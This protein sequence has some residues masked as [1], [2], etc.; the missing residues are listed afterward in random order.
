MNSKRFGSSVPSTLMAVLVALAS[1]LGHAGDD[2]TGMWGNRA[3]PDFSTMKWRPPGNNDKGKMMVNDVNLLASAVGVPHGSFTLRKMPDATPGDAFARRG[4]KGELMIYYS[5]SFEA[6]GR[7]AR[8]DYLGKYITL[9]HEIAHHLLG[10]TA[11]NAPRIT[12][13]DE[14]KAD[15]LGACLW[16]YAIQQGKR[17]Q[18]QG[19]HLGPDDHK[20]TPVYYD[21]FVPYFTVKHKAIPVDGIHSPVVERLK[22]LKSGFDYPIAVGR[23]SRNL[24]H[25]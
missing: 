4:P 25:P 6:E 18:G 1:P 16:R 10:H 11:E 5:A 9:A 24:P 22:W 20:R 21:E 15:Q 23:C 13:E 14:L 7:M 17:K 8:D 19:A 3:V 12:K 2:G